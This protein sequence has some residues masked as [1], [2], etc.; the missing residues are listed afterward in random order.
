[1]I[2]NDLRRQPKKLDSDRLPRAWLHMSHV[3][4]GPGRRRHFRTSRIHRRCRTWR[5]RCR[6]EH[7]FPWMWAKAHG[8]DLVQP[9]V[10]DPRF[11]E[12][13]GEN[14]SLLEESLIIFECLQR[15]FERRRNLPD[16]AIPQLGGQRDPRRQGLVVRSPSPPVEP[17]HKHRGECEVRIARGIGAP[18]LDTLCL[19]ALGV[20]GIRQAAERF[21]CEYT[22]LTGAS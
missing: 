1:M 22:R 13:I 18:K 15:L 11:D 21:R 8:V 19:R 12:I 10:A 14:T 5:I 4:T 6:N 3:V 2:Y 16:L 9:L 20:E 17:G 7:E